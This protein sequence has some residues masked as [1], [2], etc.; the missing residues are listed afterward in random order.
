MLR[1]IIDFLYR[2]FSVIVD[3]GIIDIGG[4]GSFGTEGM[5][6]IDVA[7][8]GTIGNEG[9]GIIAIEGEGNNVTEGLGIMGIIAI[10]GSSVSQGPGVKAGYDGSGSME[11]IIGDIDGS[12]VIF[13]MTRCLRI[14]PEYLLAFWVTTIAWVNANTTASTSTKEAFISTVCEIVDQKEGLLCSF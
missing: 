2:G 5:G 13:F 9:K 8:E 10:P 11:G 14:R 3:A 7:G 6:F 4:G 12:G 1:F